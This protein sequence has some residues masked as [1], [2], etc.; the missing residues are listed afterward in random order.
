M[1]LAFNVPFEDVRICQNIRSGFKTTANKEGFLSQD[2]TGDV[3]L[4]QGLELLGVAI[5]VFQVGSGW[6]DMG[7]A[8]LDSS[9]RSRKF[10]VEMCAKNNRIFH[11]FSLF[12]VVDPAPQQLF[13]V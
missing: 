6:A 10:V 8:F 13:E 7:W 11:A 9:R 4:Y 12:I 3:F 1:L 2:N 5:V